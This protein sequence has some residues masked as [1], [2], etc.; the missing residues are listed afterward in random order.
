MQ[1]YKIQKFLEMDKIPQEKATKEVDPPEDWP[2]IGKVQFDNISL[3]YRKKTELVLKNLSFTIKPGQKVGVV[4]RTGAGK[5]TLAL[6][7][8][9]IIELAEGKIFIDDIEIEKV[10]LQLLRAKI[11][12][13]PQDP[14]LFAGTLR[15]NLDPLNQFK[16]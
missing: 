13:I 10:D 11:T 14:T 9:R 7:I 16:D 6:T 12:V 2:A 5:S 8:S 15:F 1:L 4:G 3:R